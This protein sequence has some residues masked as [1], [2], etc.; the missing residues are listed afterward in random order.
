MLKNDYE[1]ALK[2]F[3]SALN[4]LKIDTSE[5]EAKHIYQGK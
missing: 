1:R 4:E 3:E 5:G 2:I